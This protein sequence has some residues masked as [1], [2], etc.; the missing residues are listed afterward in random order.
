MPLVK[1]V[2]IKSAYQLSRTLRYLKKNDTQRRTT[3]ALMRNIELNSDILDNLINIFVKNDQYRKKR[4]NGVIA[5]HDIISFHPSNRELLV[6][7]PHA[8]YDMVNYYLEIRSPNGLAYAKVHTNKQHI[9]AHCIFSSNE[10]ESKKS[11]RISKKEF[12]SV[13]YALQLYQKKK[14]PELS[15]SIINQRLHK[16][17]LR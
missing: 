10:R 2:S 6:S 16:E 9:H 5:F 7:N 14:Y 1:S 11:T 15:R 13:K 4:S 12:E 8:L 3:F 17:R